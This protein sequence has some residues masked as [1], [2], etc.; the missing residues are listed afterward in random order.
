MHCSGEVGG[1]P[2]PGG[3]LPG[4][5]PAPGWCPPVD[6]LLEG[7]VVSQHSLRQPPPVNRMI[8]RCKNITLPQTSFAG[9][10]KEL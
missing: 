10:N 8:D 9:G 6:L 7:M 5:V 2:I 3:L 1:L 4:G